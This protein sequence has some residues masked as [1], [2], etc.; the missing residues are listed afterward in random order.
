MTP[1]TTTLAV[2][3]VAVYLSLSIEVRDDRRGTALFTYP[4]VML[5]GLAMWGW[6]WLGWGQQ[7]WAGILARCEQVYVAMVFAG[8][9]WRALWFGLGVVN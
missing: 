7:V 5:T 1:R 4:L 2:T 8:I 9:G 3:A 6:A